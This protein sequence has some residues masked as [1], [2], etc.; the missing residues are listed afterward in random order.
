[1]R[2]VLRHLLLASPPLILG[3]GAGWGFALSQESCGRMVG[4]LFAAKCRGTLLEYQMLFQTAGMA[5]GWLLAALLGIVWE[6]RRRR[7]VQ[8]ANPE[9]GGSS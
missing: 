4:I 3:L 8:R 7:D 2:I 1:M 5:I 6:L 9:S